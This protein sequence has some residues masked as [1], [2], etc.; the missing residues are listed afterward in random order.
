MFPWTR[1]LPWSHLTYHPKAL[2][3]RAEESSLSSREWAYTR[4]ALMDTFGPICPLLDINY[5]L[6]TAADETDHHHNPSGVSHGSDDRCVCVSLSS[7]LTSAMTQQNTQMLDTQQ[8]GAQT[9][10]TFF[11]KWGSLEL[12]VSARCRRSRR[13]SGR[14]P[15]RSA[16]ELKQKPLVRSI[17]LLCSDHT[18]E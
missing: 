12:A 11:S 2:I 3:P 8:S 1:Q 13:V 7:S 10:L 6:T 5:W 17:A 15:V 9:E 18:D 4:E 16:A 14:V